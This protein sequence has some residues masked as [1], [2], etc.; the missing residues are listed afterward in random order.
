MLVRATDAVEAAASLDSVSRLL[1]KV[2]APLSAA[3]V[4]SVL[5]GSGMG[6]ALHPLMTDLPIGFWT[7][8]SVL[9]LFGG[10]GS[11]KAASLLVGSGV[12]SAVPTAL[13]GLAEW[14]ETQRPESRVGALHAV[15]NVVALAS[16]VTS[17]RLRHAGRHDAGRA[18]SLAG[19]GVV[20]VSGYLGGHLTSARKVGTRDRAFL[21]DGVGPRLSRPAAAT[22]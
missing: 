21:D 18:V 15:L 2:S 4:R 22:R 20:A 17:W 13:T 7:S 16:M 19:A 3:R 8:A 1:G 12:L 14:R 10:K 11:R 6:H 9:D 5:L